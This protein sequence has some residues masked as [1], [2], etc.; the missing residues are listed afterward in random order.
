[1]HE[2]S[3][4]C[5]MARAVVFLSSLTHF[6]MSNLSIVDH[7]LKITDVA[8]LLLAAAAMK[9]IKTNISRESRDFFILEF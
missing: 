4:S 2:V 5:L 8:T 9:T 1:M 7:Y 3:F 6:F